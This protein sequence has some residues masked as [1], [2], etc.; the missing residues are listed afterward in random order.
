MGTDSLSSPRSQSSLKRSEIE[1]L[2]ASSL[3]LIDREKVAYF[4]TNSNEIRSYLSEMD[5]KDLYA[6]ILLRCL[7]LDTSIEGI[8]MDN[9]FHESFDPDVH[10]IILNICLNNENLIFN[11]MYK[12]FKLLRFLRTEDAVRIQIVEKIL[13]HE[14]IKYTFDMYNIFQELYLSGNVD[15]EFKI[16][17]K[18]I[19]SEHEFSVL[20]NYYIK[21]PALRIYNNIK[22]N[23]IKYYLK[24]NFLGALNLLNSNRFY[25]PYVFDNLYQTAIVNEI[26]TYLES[27][28]PS[29]DEISLT[30]TTFETLNLMIQGKEVQQR[31]IIKLCKFKR[32]DYIINNPGMFRESLDLLD[33][34]FIIEPEL[35][36]S[37]SKD[38]IRNNISEYHK[39][40]NFMEIADT[41]QPQ[42][43]TFVNAMFEA[44]CEQKSSNV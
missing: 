15:I 13:A 12:L 37:S 35:I 5:F 39:L 36:Y 6:K 28:T 42:K 7:S 31:F 26:L 20:E 25:Q 14:N 18:L 27:N 22:L 43:L 1:N 34:L 16:L 4:F 44:L 38:L 32:A 30:I 2:K 40:K 8:F 9:T 41:S 17:Q 21:L 19:G 29:E 3:D 33:Y 23:L 10:T 11:N 24:R